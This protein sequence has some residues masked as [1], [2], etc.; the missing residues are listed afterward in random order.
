MGEE[1]AVHVETV[2]D[3][4]AGNEN[5]GCSSIPELKIDHR[6]LVIDTGKDPEREPEQE[7]ETFPCKKQEKEASNED[8]KSEV[9]NPTVSPREN[10]LSCQDITSQPMEATCSD[11][12]SPA[13]TL[14]EE[15]EGEPSCGENVSRVVDTPRD[16]VEPSVSTTHVILEVPKHAS[17]SG[18][19]KITF[20][21]SKK[22][23][24]YEAQ[25]TEPVVTDEEHGRN[26]STWVDLG[27]ELRE[28]RYRY[29]CAPNKE[30]KMS[31]K[32]VPNY[33]TNVKKL[34]STGILDGARV[35]YI[36]SSCAREL[37]GI[38]DGGG[39]LCGC[40]SCNF[41]RVLSAYEFE[42]HAGAKTRHPNNH[43]YLENGRPIYNII[44]ELKT[45]P[46]SSLDEVL[47]S[48]AGSSI[49]EEFFQVWKASLQQS[50]GTAGAD[51]KYYSKPY[52]AHSSVC[53][54]SSPLEERIPLS[55]SSFA[56]KHLVGY[57]PYLESLEERKTSLKRPSSYLASS[58]AT[59]RR[60]N[61]LHR[62]LFMPNGLPD[63]AELAYYVKGQKLLGGYKQGNGIV[64]NCCDTEISPSQFEAHAG[65]AA[66]RQPYR[67]IYTSNGLTLHDIAISLANGQNVTS[68]VSDDMCSKCGDGGDLIFCQSCPRA[69]HAVCLGLRH[70]PQG[71]WHC[72]DCH[73]SGQDENFARPIIIRLTRVVK[74][75]EYEGG[76]VLCRAQDFTSGGVFDDR[77]V[78]LCDQC[79]KEFHVG[80]LRENGVCDLKEFPD[81][82]FC[83]DDCISIYIA[84]QDSV[85]CGLQMIP[86]SHLNIID[87]KHG[88]KGLSVIEGPNNI[89][90]RILM[91][92]SRDDEH[93]SLLS[94]AAAIF[95][96]CF[97]PIVARS[98][99]DLIPVMVFGRNISD[100]EFQGM[101]CVLLIVN[102]VV[103]SAGL[104]RVFNKEVAELPLVATSREHQ[105]KGYFQALFSCIERLL[106]S[107]SVENLVLPAAEEAE[108][109]WTR[110]FGFRNMS[111][112]RVSKYT[113]EFQL[114]IFKGTSL[115]E[116]EVPRLLQ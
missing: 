31:K 63:G 81:K 76:C 47:K 107:L 83:S 82:W 34:L 93:L 5:G 67:H 38:I 96:E 4:N 49:N 18:I 111:E 54:Q 15:G 26:Y 46:L 36:F 25:V 88:E 14:S 12:S 58:S 51:K 73:L 56:P 94:R 113:R 9:L 109:I 10:A 114:T 33:P 52:S 86:A 1:V 13:E 65:M 68:G 48:V 104:L 66:R 60:D 115:L 116:K 100:Q 84:L 75:A 92:K 2:A 78:I 16:N 72:P 106:C 23:E 98:G 57:Q 80:C 50:N 40:P 79:D 27:T 77:T 110:R 89:Q 95:R 99:R 39:Y 20:K 70:A 43:I 17:S 45:A 61:D 97:D 53:C 112:A 69:F 28:S 41:T 71:V 29:S 101:Y 8:V 24:D 62:A 21:F 35:K 85:A 102:T 59:K 87:R 11:N 22:K 30:L 42:Q 64:C 91:G 32:I 105:G 3:V 37:D 6:C 103:V 7:P 44:Q 74:T 19:R 90:W 108:S 55:S